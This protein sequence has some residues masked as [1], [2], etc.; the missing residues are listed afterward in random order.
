MN[1]GIVLDLENDPQVHSD[2]EWENASLRESIAKSSIVR[3]R[4]ES[5]TTFFGKGKLNEIGLF[6]KE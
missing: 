1:G 3:C 6:I 5:S 4:Q 2:T